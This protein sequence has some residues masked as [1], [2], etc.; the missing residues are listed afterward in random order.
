MGTAQNWESDWGS[1]TPAMKGA[2]LTSDATQVWVDVR[3]PTVRSIISQVSP[4]LATYPTHVHMQPVRQ[5][6]SVGRR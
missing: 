6:S 3:A 4:H 5:N 1:F 2:V